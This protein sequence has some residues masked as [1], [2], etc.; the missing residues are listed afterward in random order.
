MMDFKRSALMTDV[1]ELWA[2][3]LQRLQSVRR[4][5]DCDKPSLIIISSSSSSSSRCMY[6]RRAP[7]TD[8]LVDVLIATSGNDY[9]LQLL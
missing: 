9:L 8:D 7:L 5:D 6:C 2:I 1:S 4:G 3:V